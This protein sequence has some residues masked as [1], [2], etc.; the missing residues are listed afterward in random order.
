M[1]FFKD[2]SSIF[3]NTN[4][5]TYFRD[6]LQVV[7]SGNLTFTRAQKEESKNDFRYVPKGVNGSE[8]RMKIVW[9]KCVVPNLIDL[10]KFVAI[11]STNAAK[12]FN[13]FPQKGCIAEGSDADLVIWNHK[14]N[15]I[16]SSKSH[17]HASDYNIFEGMKITGSPEYVIVKGK[18][19]FEDNNVRVSEGSGQF[20][21]LKPL[22]HILYG[23]DNNGT[24]ITDKF[25]EC[26]KLDIDQ[27]EFEDRDYVPGKTDSLKSSSTQVTHTARAPRP[28]NQRDLQ[29]SSFSIS[30]G[31][32]CIFIIFSWFWR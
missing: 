24:D 21:Q 6:D 32:Q 19:C 18:V 30:K 7:S 27:E 14:A 17:H 13:I 23:N 3:F 28:E 8:D 16:I 26:V 20:V 25:E 31:E 15:Q 2:Q 4:L 29:S 5:F 11:T 9:E 22:S 1:F 12:I 10:Q